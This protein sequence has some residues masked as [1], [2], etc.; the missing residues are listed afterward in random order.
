M[1]KIYNICLVI[2]ALIITC[3]CSSI[4]AQDEPERTKSNESAAVK[5]ESSGDSKSKLFWVFLTAGKKT[6]GIE[7][8]TIEAMQAAHL[9]NFKR[10]ADEGS[11]L[12]AG[13]MSDPTEKLKGIAIVRAMDNK[14]LTV[15]FQ[16]DE[17]IKGGIRKIEATEMTLDH[18]IINVSQA[19]SG[20]QEYRLVMLQKMKRD[21]DTEFDLGPSNAAIEEMYANKEL[22]LAVTLDETKYG[23][24]RI[25]VLNKPEDEAATLNET[26]NQI[27]AVKQG[28][29][30]PD[31]IPLFLGKGTLKP[32]S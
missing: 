2:P 24:S 9:K 30:K 19:R 22:R 26:L 7:S 4:L 16:D 15:M 21:S 13:S 11:L 6:D 20:M 1:R 23:R 31:V 27:P 29:W 3:W 18:G 5:M 12:A 8:E 28:Y 17:Y 32:A 25:L 14:S 10:L